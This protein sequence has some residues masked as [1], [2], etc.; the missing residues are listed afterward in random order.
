MME[1]HQQRVVGTSTKVEKDYLRLTQI[2]N[3]A[4]V[5]TLETL[6]KAFELLMVRWRTKSRRDYLYVGGQ[7]KSLRQDLRVQHIRTTFTAKVYEENARI[8][9]EVG[10]LSEFNQCQDMLHSQIL[11]LG[12]TFVRERR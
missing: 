9:L 7:F 4:E 6:Q 3:P 11:T 10:D 2:A 1:W 12:L 5:R 8:C